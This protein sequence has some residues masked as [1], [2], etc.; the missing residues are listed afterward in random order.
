MLDNTKLQKC[1]VAVLVILAVF[2]FSKTISEWKNYKYIGSDPQLRN[3]ITVEGKGEEISKSDIAT[4]SFTVTKESLVVGTAQ[5]EAAVLMN[6]S[7]SFLGNNGVEEKDI[8]TTGYNI[9][10]RY[11]YDN[12]SNYYP[13]PEGNRRLVAYEVTQ[14]VE[15][16]IR[17]IG[18]AGKLLSGLGEIGV[19]NISGLSFGVDNEEQVI[20]KAREKAIADAKEKAEKLADALGVKLVR[21]VSFYEGGNYPVYFGKE[22]AVYGMGGDGMTVPPSIPSG[23]N[24]IIS[25]VSITYEIK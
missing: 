2:I 10:P 21:I 18:N 6:Q 16:K 11:E 19:S 17:D 24:Q 5:N 15:V 3:V 22:A 1:A 12:L 25:N 4:F 23:E 13:R 14:S 7:L 20:A 9:Y 8:K